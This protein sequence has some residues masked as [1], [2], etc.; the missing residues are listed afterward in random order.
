MIS[1]R[2]R[3]YHSRS[4]L[5]TLTRTAVTSCDTHHPQL[6]DTNWFF[7]NCAGDSPM[8]TSTFARSGVMSPSSSWEGLY[9]YIKCT[10]TPLTVW[11]LLCNICLS[12]HTGR[13]AGRLS[14]QIWTKKQHAGSLE[15][16][17]TRAWMIIRNFRSTAIVTSFREILISRLITLSSSAVTLEITKIKDS[18]LTRAR[19]SRPDGKFWELLNIL[20]NFCANNRMMYSCRLTVCTVQYSTIHSST[21]MSVAA[22]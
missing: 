12:N 14:P 6:G 7:M 18:S 21:V 17:S 9:I 13:L 8:T 11:T 10:V 16:L 22:S 2:I 1:C 3:W 5:S 20:K 15:S 19:C 4:H